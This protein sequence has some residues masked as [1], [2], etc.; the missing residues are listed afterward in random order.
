MFRL[1]VSL[2][3]FS[4]DMKLILKND[5]SRTGQNQEP[6]RSLGFKIFFKQIQ[7]LEDTKQIFKLENENMNPQMSAKLIKWKNLG[8]SFGLLRSLT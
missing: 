3:I 4:K 7:H 1:I 5:Y 2:A 6:W 8:L